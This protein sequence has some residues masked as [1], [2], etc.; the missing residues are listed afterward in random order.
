MADWLSGRDTCLVM[1]EVSGKE[2]QA[3]GDGLPVVVVV[4]VVVVVGIRWGLW[5]VVTGCRKER[6][7]V[8]GRVVGYY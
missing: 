4:V 6:V 1:H 3:A 7:G 5:S 8:L 2:I